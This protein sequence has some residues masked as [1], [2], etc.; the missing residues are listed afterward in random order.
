MTE[1]LR[2]EV[3]GELNSKQHQYLEVTYQSGKHL[4]SLINDILDLAKIESGKLDLMISPV[5]V[6]NLCHASLSFIEQ[7]ACDKNIE[8]MMQVVDDIEEIYVDEIRMRQAIINL[9]GNAVKFTP[10]GGQIALM[11]R[12]DRVQQTIQ[13]SVMDTGIGIAPE[14]M[15][16]LFQSFVQI[17]SSL[18]RLYGGTG[19]GLA[20]V[21]KIVEL[22]QG[23][24]A[25][26][27]ALGQG[28]CFTISLP[29]DPTFYPLQAQ[30]IL[31]KRSPE[32][33]Y[34]PAIRRSIDPLVLLAEDHE[35]NIETFSSYLIS[36]GY[37]L[38]V[39]V[40]GQQAVSLAK[41]H[42]P[43]IILMDVQMPQLDGLTAIQQIR[44]LPALANTPIIALTALA[45]SGDRERCLAAGANEYLTKPVKLKRLLEVMK[46]F[47]EQ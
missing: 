33:A 29:D 32:Q 40:D 36:H 28:S 25:V 3:Y 37:R 9:L 30:S 47:C 39:A 45:M 1:M 46:Q 6:Q 34:I 23:S 35:A 22:H 17:D 14:N 2:N 43:D 11:V 5:A 16:K 8:L 20:L 19:L 15:P 31:S 7:T 44:Q 10:D 27:S 24:V 12:R 42:Q 18:S 26:E 4:L 38:L 13:F 41:Q 21:K